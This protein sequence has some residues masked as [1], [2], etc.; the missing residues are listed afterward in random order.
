MFTNTNVRDFF[1]KRV[2]FDDDVLAIYKKG[3]IFVIG[4]NV[5]SRITHKF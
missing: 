4:K 3:Y 1:K 2:L 5:K